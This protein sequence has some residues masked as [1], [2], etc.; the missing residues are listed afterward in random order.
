MTIFEAIILGLVQGI[1]EFLPIS[2]S[3]H[4]VITQMLF[5]ISFPGFGFEILLHVGS[6]LA[7][8]IYYR[9]DLIDLLTGFFLYIKNRSSEH[10]V[11]FW[12]SIYILVATFI[13]GVAGILFEGYIS[14]ALKGPTMI[15][16]SLTM[17]GI[18]L[19]II[20]R[21][22][23]TGNRTEKDMT[24]FD[25]VLIGIGQSLALIPGLSRSGTTLVVGMFAGLS[26]ETAVR[27]SFLLSIPVILG[28]TVLAVKDLLN[29]ELLAVTGVFPLIVAIIVTFIS[30]L[31]GIVWFI[32]F[33]KKSKLIYFA[34]YCF[35]L[36]LFVFIF[37]GDVD[38][39]LF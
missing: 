20:E 14:T 36:A 26:K 23:K 18:F 11:S 33:L 10:K 19:I 38:P 31:L 5:N 4:L 9:K 24:L 35:I 37:L 1:T 6:V 7:V 32:N 13:T 21:V 22:V 27:Y 8:I 28:S 12:F 39:D 29:G 34:I 3:A 30:S 17:T 15:A 2:S 25:S 16:I